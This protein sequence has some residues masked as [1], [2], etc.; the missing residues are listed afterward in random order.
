VLAAT[1][2]FCTCCCCPVEPTGR[3]SAVKRLPSSMPI[4][5]T[6]AIAH[7]LLFVPGPLV[8]IPLLSPP[9]GLSHPPATSVCTAAIAARR[10]L[11]FARSLVGPR[12][13]G[14]RASG[15]EGEGRTKEEAE[16]G[17][18]SGGRGRASARVR[19]PPMLVLLLFFLYFDTTLIILTQYKLQYLGN[20]V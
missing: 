16:K 9:A 11:W 1:T 12:V 3:R 10:R 17:E 8:R 5:P 13:S 6:I 2:R 19:A 7:P 18:I 15:F 4:A 20:K 14:V